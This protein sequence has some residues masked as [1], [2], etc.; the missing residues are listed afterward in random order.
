MAKRQHQLDKIT[1]KL[2]ESLMQTIERLPKSDV[3]FGSVQLSKEEQ[4]E[5]YLGVRDNPEEWQKLLSSQGL[6]DTMRYAR[7]M[8]RSLHEPVEVDDAISADYE[9]E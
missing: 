3:P 5:Q 8:E 9:G 2:T 4:I 1:D 7:D 6:R